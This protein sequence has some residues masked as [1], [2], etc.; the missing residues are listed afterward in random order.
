M[1][2]DFHHG[3]TYVIARFAGFGHREAETIAYCSQYVDDATNS[4]A[5]RFN[6]G[7][8]Y[9][10]I[11]SAHKMLD[12]RNFEKLANHFVWI[13]FHFLPGNG[14]RRAGENPAGSFVEKIVCRP[15]SFVAREMVGSCIQEKDA[16]YG[17]H[18]LGISMHVYADTWAHQGFAGVNHEINEVQTLVDSG[19]PDPG[20]TNKLKDFFGDAFDETVSRFVGG[21]LPLGHGPALS[22]PDR[23]Y[24]SWHYRDS[25][26]QIVRRDNTEIFLEAAD[27]MCRA[28]QQ[29]RV[30]ERNIEAPGLSTFARDPYKTKGSQSA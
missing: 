30:G 6:N 1:Q 14:G 7:A 18:R 8:M 3:G 4:G 19:H 21:T 27:G 28:M 22:F 20:F 17:L 29:F 26:G 15:D 11:S 10:R 24:L 2:I 9:S 25:R 23:P 5:I 13:P 16:P 12:Y